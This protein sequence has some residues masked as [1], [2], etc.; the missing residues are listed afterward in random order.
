MPYQTFGIHSVK[1]S[2]QKIFKYFF[3]NHQ[4]FLLIDTL[5]IIEDKKVLHFPSEP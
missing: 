2:D 1:E 5:Y 4:I 3:K